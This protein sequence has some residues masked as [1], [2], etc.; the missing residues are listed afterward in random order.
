MISK[1]ALKEFK[2]I[3]KKK[4]GEDISDKDALDEAT[5]LLN[6]YK[7]VYLPVTRTD[8]DKLQ[9]RREKTK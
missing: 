3:Y 2:R 4:F 6:L 7:A 1:E 9:K 8:Y 5:N